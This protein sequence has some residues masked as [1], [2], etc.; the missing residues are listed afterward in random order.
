METCFK[1]ELK[2]KKKE[3]EK[4]LLRTHKVVKK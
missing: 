2:K 1:N 3:L 4:I